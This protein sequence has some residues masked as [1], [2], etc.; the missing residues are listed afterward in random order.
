[1]QAKKIAALAEA[2]YVA[3]AP[4]NPNGPIATCAAAHLAASI[5]NFLILETIGSEE[6]KALQAEI[7]DPPLRIEDGCI[8]LP[9]GPGLGM[10]LNL[11]ACR[12]HPYQ[13]FEGWR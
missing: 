6:D 7:V 10:T 12:R 11:A 2:E 1:M 3:I 4:H 5:P 13:T 9:D 8:V